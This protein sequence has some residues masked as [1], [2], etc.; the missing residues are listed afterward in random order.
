[1]S[2]IIEG[3]KVEY[4]TMEGAVNSLRRLEFN[5][6]A[7][8]SNPDYFLIATRG[9]HKIGLKHITQ[10]G[11]CRAVSMTADALEF[12]FSEIFSLQQKSTLK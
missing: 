4:P 10:G 7:D 5:L 8:S 6:S 3:D 9:P 1:M 11:A 2:Y 12:L